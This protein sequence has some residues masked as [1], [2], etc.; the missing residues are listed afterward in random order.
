MSL[1]CFFKQRPP[2]SLVMDSF[3]GSL[4][5]KQTWKIQCLPLEQKTSLLAI[6]KNLG[7]P[8]SGF[9]SVM[10]PIACPGMHL[11]PSASYPWDSGP[12]GSGT[13]MLVLMLLAV[14]L[15]ISYFVFGQGILIFPTSVHTTVQAN[16]IGCKWGK[17]SYPSQYK[18]DS[19]Q[20]LPFSG[21]EIFFFQFHSQKY[22]NASYL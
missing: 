2:V 5:N 13:N 10:Q 9:H 16:L 14:L 4:Y 17:I 21:L 15:V 11:G 12:R 7:C 20:S 3:K 1:L 6:R 8:S 18:Y 19:S 22:L